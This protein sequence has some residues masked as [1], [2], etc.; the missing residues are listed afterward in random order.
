MAKWLKSVLFGRQLS[1]GSENE[2]PKSFEDAFQQQPLERQ[3]SMEV[4]EQQ[5]TLVGWSK[6]ACWG[7]KIMNFNGLPFT[8]YLALL[9]SI[10]SLAL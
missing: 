1:Y 4:E 6:S 3:E 7:R 9:K 2:D 10:Q 8:K 5:Q